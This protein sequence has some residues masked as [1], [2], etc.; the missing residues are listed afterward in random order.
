MSMNF[1]SPVEKGRSAMY[2]LDIERYENIIVGRFHGDLVLDSAVPLRRELEHVL[3]STKV[4]DLALDLSMAGKVDTSGIGAL[5]GAC[6]T[7]R[8]RGK[9]LMLYSPAPLVVKT[10]SDAEIS[11]FFPMVEDEADLKAR[12]HKKL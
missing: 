1:A 3:K 7:A 8:S 9:R 12:M 11:A 5:V 2:T 10:L 6:T 4:K